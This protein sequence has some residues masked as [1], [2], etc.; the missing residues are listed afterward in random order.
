[1]GFKGRIV[2]GA[3][4]ALRNP[5]VRAGIGAGAAA[6][7]AGAL[8]YGAAGGSAP[9]VPV[10]ASGLYRVDRWGN[11]TKVTQKRRKKSYRMPRAVAEQIRTANDL[12]RAVTYAVIAGSTRA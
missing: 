7:G 5:R 6:A 11:I 1:M 8:G 3:G 10:G 4:R 9:N 2:K 12:T